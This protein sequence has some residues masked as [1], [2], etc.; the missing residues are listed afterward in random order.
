MKITKINVFHVSAGWRPWSFIKI[1]TDEGLIGWSEC[2]DSH[3]SP[4]GISSEVNYIT[5]GVINLA[6]QYDIPVPEHL[7]AYQLLQD[8]V[9]EFQLKR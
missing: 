3:G 6:K 9:K 7:R 8:R 5:G 2:T 4:L 1:S